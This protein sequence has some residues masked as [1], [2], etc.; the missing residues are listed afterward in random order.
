MGSY[1]VTLV[2]GKAEIGGGLAQSTSGD[3]QANQSALLL[4][5][6]A[7]QHGGGA[8]GGTRRGPGMDGS[9]SGGPVLSLV[10]PPRGNS[11][12]LTSIGSPRPILARR[13]TSEP[14]SSQRRA[15][16][17]QVVHP[18][19]AVRCCG[20]DCSNCRRRFVVRSRHS[21]ELP[22]R[23]C[24]FAFDRS[25]SRTP[26]KRVVAV[27]LK[28]HAPLVRPGHISSLANRPTG[29]SRVPTPPSVDP[30]ACKAPNM[31]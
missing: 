23:T 10:Q 1:T 16:I 18:I 24:S 3:Q 8:R 14:R 30:G 13:S 25:S 12:A 29:T 17:G 26:P 27:G 4:L 9:T 5:P 15:D 2:R 11:F 31:A 19:H 20:L 22:A 28:P 21:D 7:A 6:G